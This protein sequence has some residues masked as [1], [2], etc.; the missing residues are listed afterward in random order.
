[1]APQLRRVVFIIS[2]RADG[3]Q[4]PPVGAAEALTFSGWHDAR[5]NR[6]AVRAPR[7]NRPSTLVRV[8]AVL[9]YA[10]LSERETRKLY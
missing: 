2:A 9:L 1:V 3:E 6:I 8:H 4:R 10:V 5:F 7:E